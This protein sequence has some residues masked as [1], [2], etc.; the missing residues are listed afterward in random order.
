LNTNT[1][2][3]T[4]Q[5]TGIVG[6][7]ALTALALSACAAADS[8]GESIAASGQALT[9]PP[10]SAGFSDIHEDGVLRGWSLVGARRWV[11]NQGKLT[12]VSPGYA[13]KSGGSR[14]GF[15]ISDYPSADDGTFEALLTADSWNG[16][17]GGAVLRWSSPSSFYYVTV[18]PANMWESKLVFHVNTMD[19]S[20][21]QVVAKNFSIGSTFK[22]KV[23]ASGDTFEI[24]LDDVLRATVHDGT[25]RSG[26]VGYAYSSSWENLFA[27]Q[28]SQWR[29][30]PGSTPSS[31]VDPKAGRVE[32]K[33]HVRDDAYWQSNMLKPRLYVENTGE[34]TVGDFTAYYLFTAE[35]GKTPV[36]EDWWTPESDVSLVNLGDNQYA[37]EYHFRGLDLAPGEITPSSDGNLIGV[38]YSD[39]SAMDKSNDFSNPAGPEMQLSSKIPVEGAFKSASDFTGAGE[40][41]VKLVGGELPTKSVKMKRLKLKRVHCDDTTDDSDLWGFEDYVFAHVTLDGQFAKTIKLGQMDEWGDS[42]DDDPKNRYF[43]AENNRFL[44]F[45]S[46]VKVSLFDYEHWKVGPDPLFDVTLF[47][48]NFTDHIGTEELST[49]PGSYEERFNRD[50]KYDLSYD[51]EEFDETRT[52]ATLAEYQLEKFRESSAPGVWGPQVVKNTLIAEMEER[53]RPRVLRDGVTVW[54]GASLVS[55]EQLGY[56]GP[57]AATFWL[58]NNRPLRYVLFVRDVFENGSFKGA[59]HTYTASD[60]LRACNVPSARMERTERDSNGDPLPAPNKVTSA[61]ADWLVMATLSDK[62]AEDDER[63]YCD[64]SNEPRSESL[65]NQIKG[66][67]NYEMSRWFRDVLG[68]PYVDDDSTFFWGEA[69]VLEKADA[70]V[71]KGGAAVLAVRH[72]VFENEEDD[73]WTAPDHYVAFLGSLEVEHG[74][75]YDWNTGHFKFRIFDHA[76]LSTI[77]LNET[78]LEDSVF[79]AT[80][81]DKP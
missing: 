65:P 14:S 47:E 6:V 32:L 48:G 8:A 12:T 37:V 53:L 31:A 62:F 23:V 80:L 64:A 59:E 3:L 51:I 15:L 19:E 9:A 17:A 44:E 55:Q 35:P 26:R 36:L 42:T 60:A 29:D 72:G 7:I 25:N 45:T 66:T 40:P 2:T 43:T 71:R 61:V 41:I 30:A 16:N 77:A 13:A 52:Y 20:K 76:H 68:Y 18:K 24:Y 56:C 46:S 27:A 75:W 38:Y 49:T 28:E 63:I 81:S 69:T 21:G 39:W 1:A 10:G 34:V 50:G 57:A 11:E 73:W 5:P 79:G 22:L 58:I 70:V 78:D 67:S 74:E 33:V 54:P 4:R